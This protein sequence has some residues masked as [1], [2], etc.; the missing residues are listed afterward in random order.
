[1]VQYHKEPKTKAS[2]TGG[3]K[4]SS[5]D[6]VKVHYGGFF[7]R[8]HIDKK[9]P[10]A[11]YVSRSTKGGNAKTAVRVVE[12]ANVAHK[13]KVV[14]SKVLTVIE[15]PD[16]RH[17]TRENVVTKGALV[18]TELGKVRV[19]SR[20]TQHGVVNGILVESSKAAA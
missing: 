18:E 6:K 11:V 12:F 13:G 8:P 4:R 5:R 15:S 19:T 16:N 3:R 2:G 9:A 7:S 14:K 10:K 17:Y 1:M 20:P